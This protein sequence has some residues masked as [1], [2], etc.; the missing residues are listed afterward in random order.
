MEDKY[1]KLIKNSG[2]FLLGNI[3]SQGVR[4]VFLLVCTHLL[5]PE[6]YGIV[7]I[8]SQTATLALPIV[9]IG[10]AGAVFRYSMDKE[11][12]PTGVFT[13]GL[14]VIFIGSVVL[15]VLSPIFRLVNIF[16]TFITYLL[17]LIIIQ[18]IQVATKQFTRGIGKVKIFVISDFINSLSTL[19]FGIIFIFYYHWGIQGYLLSYILAYA[20]D[21]VFLIFGAKLYAY[22]DIKTISLSQMKKMSKYSLP[23]APNS[24]MWWLTETSNRYF[25]LYILGTS[26]TG[27]Y[28]VA[29]KIP[30][31][32]TLF[33]SVFFMAWQMA[34]VEEYLSEDKSQFYSKT[35]EVFW[36]G[37]VLSA[38][39]IFIV[40]HWFMIIFVSPEFYEAW[41]Y[42]PL[43]I[44]SSLFS[45]FQ[46]FIGTNYT[47]SKNTI[48]ALKTSG[49]AA[50]TSILLNIILIP[51]MGLYGAAIATLIS[52]IFVFIL[53]YFDTA[54]FVIIN[55]DWIKF[56]L[57]FIVLAIQMLLLICSFEMSYITGI[58]CFLLIV[59][60]N[61]NTLITIRK[62]VQGNQRNQTL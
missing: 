12:N 45:S 24:I 6:E 53:R 28:A 62:W 47:A 58:M 36:I 38:S 41:R 35:F 32:I 56:V 46:A 1:I 2:I 13:N 4:F 29:S 11:E 9:S 21:S 34:A 14:A 33:T 19:L 50:G 25:I 17:T 40:L 7:E 59:F 42:I 16:D 49:C 10:I 22:I 57:S 52:Y 44:L 60:I 54:K 20:F 8:I 26:M 3:G 5:I 31:L 48:G 39:S 15:L 61:K 43:L 27:I 51:L 18:M 30:G 37:M 23:L 55:I